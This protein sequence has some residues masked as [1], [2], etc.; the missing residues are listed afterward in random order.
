MDSDGWSIVADA[1]GRTVQLFDEDL[2]FVTRL[3]SD[4]PLPYTSAIAI[5]N[6]NEVMFIG[7]KNNEVTLATLEPFS[8]LPSLMVGF[9][10]VFFGV[11]ELVNSHK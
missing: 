3:G 2:K 9:L 1:G 4:F 8:D 7:R 6:F 10:T 5:N 11:L